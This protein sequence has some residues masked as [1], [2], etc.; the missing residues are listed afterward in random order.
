MLPDLSRRLAATLVLLAWTAQPLAQTSDWHLDNG[1][2]VLQLS[3]SAQGYRLQPGGPPIRLSGHVLIR[4]DAHWTPAALRL[5]QNLI[6]QSSELY[7]GQDFRYWLLE[8]SGGLP[9][10]ELLALLREQPGIQFA[11]PDMEQGRFKAASTASQ[12]DAEHLRHHGIAALWPLSRGRG[13]RI[14]II[15]DGIDL[16]HPEFAS[17]HTVF[18]Y[19]FETATLDAAPRHPG[20]TH[21]TRAAG[22]LFAAHDGQG[23]DGIAPEASLIAIRQPD[24]WTS[25]TLRSFALAKLENADV[26][27]CAWTS[28]VLLQP[29][30]DVVA[31]LARQGGGGKGAAVVFAAGNEGRHIA[32][33]ADEA[34]LSSAIVV[35]ASDARGRL[36]ASSNHGPSVD[37]LAYGAGSRAPAA[38]G[39]EAQFSGTSLA[40]SVASGVAALLLGMQPELTGPEL[41]Q[42]LGSWLATPAPHNIPAPEARHD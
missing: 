7:P 11:Q 8:S 22:I 40:A 23:L 30:A 39:G 15:D 10:P 29:V 20:D 42:A 27:L 38:G 25:N 34:A 17:L 21:G 14:A 13:V 3:L 5:P 18:Q 41:Q 37:V 32:P 4:S 16:A 28:R 24:T 26:I 6:T 35:A 12:E 36:L 1:E 33:H 2:N 9:L 19:D 31:D